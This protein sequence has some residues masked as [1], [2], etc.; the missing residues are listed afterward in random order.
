[1]RSED[2]LAGF[3]GKRKFTRTGISAR[4]GELAIVARPKNHD[5]AGREGEQVTGTT[6]TE[7][8]LLGGKTLPAQTSCRKAP[9]APHKI[10]GRQSRGLITTA[11]LTLGGSAGHLLEL[12]ICDCS[13]ANSAVQPPFRRAISPRRRARLPGHV[14]QDT[15]ALCRLSSTG[16][17]PSSRV[18]EPFSL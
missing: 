9:P 8:F 15:A 2:A 14:C 16:C 10:P 1:M 12:I 18:R 5:G 13:P 17:R 7:G 3:S 4:G 6:S 11:S